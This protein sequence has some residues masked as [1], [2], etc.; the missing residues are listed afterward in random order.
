MSEYRSF[1]EALEEAEE[2]QTRK[3]PGPSKLKPTIIIPTFWTKESRQT[4][5]DPTAKIFYEHPTD[6]DDEHP[7]LEI[8]LNSLVGKPRVGKIIIVVG[9]TD[10][11]LWARSDERV[12]SIAADFPD[13]DILVVG[14]VE[15]GAI[16]RRLEQLD[17]EAMIPSLD[18]SG[19]GAVRNIGLISASILGSDSVLFIDDDEIVESEDFIETGLFGLGLQMH[20][21]RR[22]LA[23]SGFYTNTD[24]SWQH[25]TDK[26]AWTDIFW[27]IEEAYNKTLKSVMQPSRLSPAR[28]AFG[29]CLALHSE[30]YTKMAFDPWITCGEDVDYLINLRLH[31][32]EMFIDDQWHITH[33]VGLESSAHRRF[34]QNVYRFIYEHRKLEFAKS[35]VDLARVSP[36]S[37]A[38][39]PG[40]YINATLGGRA[41]TTALLRAIKGPERSW[42]WHIATKTIKDAGAY[43]RKNCGNYFA[44]E[45]AWPLMMEKVWEDVALSS[46][47]KGERSIDRTAFTG[48][49][50]PVH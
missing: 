17:L 39:F 5:D 37:L 45:R 23:K 36:E 29:G 3:G 44:L 24:G 26:G 6:L 7:G 30:V 28:L 13:L 50:R 8:V 48:E 49:F 47:F 35:Q 20:T 9:V 42:Y 11:L 10:R 19:Y 1:A 22:L 38:P 18:L 34:R 4:L 15:V 33:T 46:Q 32:G 14:E 25:L 41:R 27:R 21:G 40:D 31:G 2:S 12:R 43:A 16:F